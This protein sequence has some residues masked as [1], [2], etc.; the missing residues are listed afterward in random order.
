MKRLLAT[1]PLFV[2]LEAEAA[3]LGMTAPLVAEHCEV[4]INA[5][6]LTKIMPETSAKVSA[7]LDVTSDE[8]KEE[9][10]V[11]A[12]EYLAKVKELP[13]SKMK[14]DFAKLQRET[15]LED[16]ASISS[17]MKTLHTLQDQLA[18]AD[19]FLNSHTQMNGGGTVD[20][21]GFIPQTAVLMD[22]HMT[23]AFEEL[24]TRG[25]NCND[26]VKTFTLKMLDS[27]VK[28]SLLQV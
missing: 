19:E 12:L 11:S 15:V 3:D 16:P 1:L 18:K 23:E 10:K 21:V 4:T 24:R 28:V 13:Y 25:I 9:E 20:V 14:A 27:Q 17:G 26:D 6:Q 8:I 22:E 5:K 2:G 7:V